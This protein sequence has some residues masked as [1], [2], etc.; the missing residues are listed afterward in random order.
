MYELCRLAH[1]NSAE[2]LKIFSKERQQ[3]GTERWL[4]IRRQA[5]DGLLTILP[6]RLSIA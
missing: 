2:E 5:K 6:G 4:P 3:E 1:F